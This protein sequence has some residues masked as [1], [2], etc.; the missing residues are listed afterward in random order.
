M[1]GG[2][3]TRMIIGDGKGGVVSVWVAVFLGVLQGLTEFF[4]VSSSGHLALFG[5][6]FGKQDEDLTFEIL[7]HMATLAAIVVYFRKDWLQ[8]LNIALRKERGDFPPHIFLYVLVSMI[9]A[10]IVGVFLKDQIEHIHGQTFW[11]GVFLIIT[12]I[13]LLFGLK[14]PPDGKPMDKLSLA[15]VFAMGCAQAFAVLPG[16][17]RSG[18]TI[19]CAL[20]LGMSR[21]A[22]ARFSF[23]MA[24]PVIGG[25][26]LL[27]VKDLFENGAQLGSELLTA[28]AAGFVAALI[29]GFFALA[30]LMKL[31]EGNRF[32]FFGFYCLPMGV[33]AM[34]L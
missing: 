18:S 3:T 19:M 8:L 6:W 32:F 22:G 5:A 24:V 12:G 10:G 14:V 30:F 23:L 29:S 7:V 13:T 11:V 2:F 1:I 9:P 31:L 25:A 34:L 15:V 21:Q 4:P 26:G 27:M 16:I 28:Y 33:L 20:F 17:S